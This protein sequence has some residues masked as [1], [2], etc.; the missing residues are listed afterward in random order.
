MTELFDFFEIK[1]KVTFL[2][3]LE[4]F[5]ICVLLAFILVYSSV[6]NVFGV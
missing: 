1:K 4:N 5:W 6:G 3:F 2:I